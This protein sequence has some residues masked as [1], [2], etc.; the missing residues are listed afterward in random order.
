LVFQKQPQTETRSKTR[1]KNATNADF[2]V[3]ITDFKTLKQEEKP[4]RSHRR[5][6]SSRAQ[7]FFIVR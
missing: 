1:C 2:I 6:F 4:A 7:T 3:K 5:R